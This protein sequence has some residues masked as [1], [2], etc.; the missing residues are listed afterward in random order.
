MKIGRKRH[1]SGCSAVSA[2]RDGSI[3]GRR[4]PIASVVDRSPT[5]RRRHD[6]NSIRRFPPDAGSWT[7][8]AGRRPNEIDVDLRAAGHHKSSAISTSCRSYKSYSWRLAAFVASVRTSGARARHLRHGCMQIRGADQITMPRLLGLQLA[9]GFNEP[10]DAYRPVDGQLV[11]PIAFRWQFIFVLGFLLAR[12]DAGRKRAALADAPGRNMV[13]AAGTIVLGFFNPLGGPRPGRSGSPAV[14]R[15][16]GSAVTPVIFMFAWTGYLPPATLGPKPLA[17]CRARFAAGFSSR[18]AALYGRL[19]R[20]GWFAPISDIFAPSAAFPSERLLR[21]PS[22][23]KPCADR[24]PRLCLWGGILAIRLVLSIGLG[25]M[26]FICVAAFR[27]GAKDR[28]PSPFARPEPRLSRRRDCAPRMPQLSAQCQAPAA[29]I[30]A[31]APCRTLPHAGQPRRS[32][33]A[34]R[35]GLVHRGIGAFVAVAQLSVATTRYWPRRSTAS[36]SRSSI[37][38]FRRGRVDHGGAVAQRSRRPRT[39]SISG[40]LAPT[41]RSRAFRPEQFEERPLDRRMA[42]GG[43]DRRRAVGLQYTPKLARDDNYE[44]IRDV[45]S[46]SPRMKILYIRR[47]EAMQFISKARATRQ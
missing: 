41:T 2:A 31:P 24:S 26:G 39:P 16:C 35:L 45:R 13:R 25:L 29:D 7:G 22:G 30:A 28:Q 11:L 40:S 14:A 18:A 27:N 20:L 43:Q 8:Q 34:H 17:V 44:A 33:F 23:V 42:E 9:T 19:G 36:T 32:A 6:L 10:A 15:R 21:L 5:I 38:R 12:P 3:A 46:R 1:P 4:R 47:Y 37:G